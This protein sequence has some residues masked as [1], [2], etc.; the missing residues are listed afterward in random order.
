MGVDVMVMEI[1]VFV[2][3]FFRRLLVLS[4]GGCLFWK[5]VWTLDTLNMSIIGE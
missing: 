3:D 5:S 1:A 4:E 2:V